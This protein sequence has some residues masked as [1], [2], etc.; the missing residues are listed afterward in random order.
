MG[1]WLGAGMID[2]QLPS[3]VVYVTET[4][5]FSSTYKQAGS[6]GALT[7]GVVCGDSSGDVLG[8]EISH[9][10]GARHDRANEASGS[11]SAFGTLVNK[12]NGQPANYH[13]IM[14]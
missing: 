5:L 11:G 14:A 10:L 12:A 3:L 1:E 2:S 7:F 6:L 9:M 13:T 8:H 4:A